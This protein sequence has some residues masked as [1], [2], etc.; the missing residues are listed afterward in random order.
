VFLG[1]KILYEVVP[2]VVEWNDPENRLIIAA[3]PMNGSI[4]GTGIIAG[5][6]RGPMT[7]GIVTA[8]GG[9]F[10]GP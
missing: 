5:V 6:T 3:G 8:L 9:G 4:G 2:P 10:L 7:N 1:A